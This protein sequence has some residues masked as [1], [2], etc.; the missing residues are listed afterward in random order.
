VKADSLWKA[1]FL[2][3][4]L[5]VADQVARLDRRPDVCR[6]DQTALVPAIVRSGIDG[7]GSDAKLL[8][9]LSRGSRLFVRQTAAAA[10]LGA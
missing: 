1:G 4:S 6:E 8:G 2:E 5:E 9:R 3:H 7:N 10:I